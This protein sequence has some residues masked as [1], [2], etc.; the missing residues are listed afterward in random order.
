MTVA[1]ARLAVIAQV[2]SQVLPAAAL[3]G[4]SAVWTPRAAGLWVAEAGE[5]E[6]RVSRLRVAVRP[7]SPAAGADR[8]WFVIPRA[9]PAAV[10][11]PCRKVYARVPEDVQMAGP[12]AVGALLLWCWRP[13]LLRSH[14]ASQPMVAGQREESARA[15]ARRAHAPACAAM[16]PPP[17]ACFPQPAWLPCGRS[18]MCQPPLLRVRLQARG[19]VSPE[20]DDSRQRVRVPRQ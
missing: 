4:K 11:E 9:H 14:A 20:P 17:A 7:P 1:G 15:G 12:G 16:G 13:L 19:L 10:P 5:I 3:A 2:A 8:Q 6:R 18:L